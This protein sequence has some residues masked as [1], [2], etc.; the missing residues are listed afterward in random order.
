MIAAPIPVTLRLAGVREGAPAAAQA[1][2]VCRAAGPQAAFLLVGGLGNTYLQTVRSFCDVPA[3]A[4]R[5]VDRGVLAHTAAV[6]GGRGARLYLMAADP[7]ELRGVSASNVPL[8]SRI[9]YP[10]W[11]GRLVGPPETPSV[12]RKDLYL[13]EV[14]PDGSARAVPGPGLI[15]P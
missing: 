13:A 3:A 10:H 6:A 2:S 8:F 1:Y 11:P 9:R 15:Q 5:K 14:L 7:A 4:L 12:E